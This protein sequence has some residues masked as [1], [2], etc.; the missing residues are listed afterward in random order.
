[1]SITQDAADSLIEVQSDFEAMF[2]SNGWSLEYKW[3][4]LNSY[5][6]A[7][8][9]RATLDFI[10]D[11]ADRVRELS[12]EDLAANDLGAFIAEIPDLLANIQFVNFPSDPDASVGGVMDVLQIINARLPKQHSGPLKVDWEDVDRKQLVPKNIAAR[13]RSLEA[14]LSLLEPRAE[15]IN[16]KIEEI[17]NA[18][19]AAERL[20]EDLAEL[21]R[22]TKQTEAM[23]EEATVALERT[24]S[25]SAEI[26]AIKDTVSGLAVKIT[27]AEQLALKLIEKSEQALRGSTGVG[28]AAAFDR[29]QKNLSWVAIGWVVGLVGA[30]VAAFFIGADRVTA[31]Q[32]VITNDSQPHIVTMNLV[33]A[34]FG[35]GG[36][37]WFAW[38]ST[39]QISMTLKLAEDYAF[40]AAV[41]KAYE[42][43]RTEA[44]EIDPL[45]KGRLFSSALDRLEEAPIRLMD[46]DNHG[47]PLQELLSNPSIRKSL[48]TVPGIVDKIQGLI[49]G[50]GALITG[51][52]GTAAVV[53]SSVPSASNDDEGTTEKISKQ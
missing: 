28:L 34:I 47:S 53:M 48:E 35:I 40:K 50:K 24:K 13:L 44:I 25:V 2:Q 6:L 3:N 29:R 33:L 27:D 19:A 16:I 37:V 22:K 20:P 10:T 23:S 42:G 11:T 52:A 8:P 46:K 14:R 5:M 38:V 41:S 4:N 9:V 12:D 39:K 17:E 45:L 32:N 30:L 43:Y 15:D 36:P 1:M 51:A 26:A 7:V 31:L 49:P 18:H 21:E